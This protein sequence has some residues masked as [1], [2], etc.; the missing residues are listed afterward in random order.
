MN[1]I[2]FITH[3]TLTLQHAKMTFMSLANSK[4]PIEFDEILIYNTHQKDLPNQEI[5]K[6][7]NYFNIEFI[8]KIV[9][10][11]Y[12]ENTHKSLGG[13]LQAIKEYCNNHYQPND[14]LLLLKSDCLLS[15]NFINELSKLKNLNNEFI[16]VAPLINAKQ[17]V[18]DQELEEYIKLPFAILSSDN[19]FFMEDE[20]LS[21]DNDFRNRPGVKPGDDI[22]KYISCTVKRDWSCHYLPNKI[23][24]QVLLSIKDWGGC[25]F[26]HLKQY[27]IGSYKSFVV[28]K[29]HSILSEN[30]K[31]E[32]PG[33]WGKWL[34]K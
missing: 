10:F 27:W 2:V 26:E 12:D 20:I 6:L 3:A 33:E 28:H 1:I 34:E 17:S 18:T 5:L 11:D 8:K 16:F 13:D 21:S 14:N 31:E 23:F 9:F 24:N 22:I 7:Y 4:D 19:T 32:R 25:S 30:R 15:I 29:Y